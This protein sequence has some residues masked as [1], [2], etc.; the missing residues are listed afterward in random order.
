[1]LV[2]FMLGLVCGVCMMATNSLDPFQEGQGSSQGAKA[3]RV[4][5]T[6]TAVWSTVNLRKA[7][8]RRTLRHA[9]QRSVSIVVF[10]MKWSLV[11]ENL[12]IPIAAASNS[13]L[14]SS[15]ALS[16]SFSL[17]LSLSLSHSLSHSL[18]LFLTFL[19]LSSDC[20]GTWCRIT[21]GYGCLEKL[22]EGGQTLDPADRVKNLLI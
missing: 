8:H 18:S 6:R 3:R 22:V 16:L 21:L 1:M 10:I 11:V 14:C 12:W 13:F 4:C 17:S 9:S 7:A 20:L 15:R 5:Q 2:L 19:T